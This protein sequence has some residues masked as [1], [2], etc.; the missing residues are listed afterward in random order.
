[1]LGGRA[2]VAQ[3]HPR[4]FVQPRFA[5]RRRVGCGSRRSMKRPLIVFFIL[6]A[7]TLLLR[8]LPH[9]SSSGPGG[10]D[11]TAT[12]PEAASGDSNAP[13]THVP[14]LPEQPEVVRVTPEDFSATAA[15]RLAALPTKKKV[16]ESAKTTDV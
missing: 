15:Q 4:R 1:M 11:S 6:V 16:L 7:I 2:R 12:K 3:T 5:R 9:S 10:S 14:A 13:D 8:V